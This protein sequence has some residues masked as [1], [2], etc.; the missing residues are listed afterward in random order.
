MTY[1]SL[2]S[3]LNPQLPIFD[4]LSKYSHDNGLAIALNAIFA[5]G[6]V[7]AGTNNTRPAQMLQ[8]LAGYYHKEPDCLFTVRIAQG[9]VHMGKGTIGLNPSS[10]TGA[11]QVGQQGKGPTALG[12]TLQCDTTCARKIIVH[13]GTLARPGPHPRAIPP[14]PQ[15]RIG[16]RCTLQRPYRPAPPLQQRRARALAPP[17]DAPAACPLP[18]PPPP[19]PPPLDGVWLLCYPNNDLIIKHHEAEYPYEDTAHGALADFAVRRVGDDGLA[20]GG[21][22]WAGAGRGLTATASARWA[23]GSPPSTDNN[24]HEQLVADPHSSACS[25]SLGNISTSA[26]HT[27]CLQY[28]SPLLAY[29]QRLEHAHPRGQHIHPPPV[30]AAAAARHR[31]QAS[32][33]GYTTYPVGLPL[34]TPRWFYL[35]TSHQPL[36]LPSFL[37]KTDGQMHRQELCPS[38]HSRLS[39]PCQTGKQTMRSTWWDAG[40]P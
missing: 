39:P 17:L 36:P 34:K 6:L 11:S 13:H 29:T 20:G 26:T 30:R 12:L 27:Q 3:G 40:K 33:P 22:A 1:C 16:A 18:V 23:T 38:A 37:S 24:E 5:M 21:D 32:D 10:P 25:L 9:L 35:L 7:G 8:Q 4:T 28:A 15:Q 31:V 19:P 2:V 14:A